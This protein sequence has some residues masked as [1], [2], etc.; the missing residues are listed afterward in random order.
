MINK[1]SIVSCL[2]FALML[3]PNCGGCKK[4]KTCGTNN[5]C[6]TTCSAKSGKTTRVSGPMSDKEVGWGAEDKK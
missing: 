3:L 2:V 1:I 5:T 6:A 4:D